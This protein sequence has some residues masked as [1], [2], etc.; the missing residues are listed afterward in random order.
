NSANAFAARFYLFKGDYA[1]V[2]E[3]TGKVLTG[4]E[5]ARTMMRPW[6]SVF[7]PM[8]A[9]ALVVQFTKSIYNFNLLMGEA[10]S[11]WGRHF[12]TRYGLGKTV[13][14]TV[15]F[16]PN[17]SGGTYAYK[18]TP[19]V[20]PYYSSNKFDE[21]FFETTIGSGF[22]DPYVMV[23]LLTADELIMNRAEAYASN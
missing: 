21:L 16:G 13:T 6:N 18:A 20:E 15:M 14:N 19:Y 23:P 7:Q 10:N 17:V 4:T 9:T 5:Q 11:V 8:I 2:I 1:K 3:H 12:Y 22:G